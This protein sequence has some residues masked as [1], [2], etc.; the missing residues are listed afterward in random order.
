MDEMTIS[1]TDD[2]PC[3][4]WCGAP[5][6]RRRGGRQQAFCTPAHSVLVGA[7]SVRHESHLRG[8]FDR[9]RGF[10]HRVSR[11]AEGTLMLSQCQSRLRTRRT[12]GSARASSAPNRSGASFDFYQAAGLIGFCTKSWAG[13]LAN[14]SA[15]ARWFPKKD[16]AGSP[17]CQP[18]SVGPKEK[19]FVSRGPRA[20]NTARSD[21][22]QGS[23]D[24]ISS[25]PSPAF[26]Q[27][28]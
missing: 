7:I 28:G 11:P 20:T 17:K 5:F 26:R 4:R 9:R 15:R 19:C 13:V 23:G 1:R 25:L 12:T 24:L 2:A 3:C 16:A 6:V 21:P 22:P 14:L 27:N 8:P 18:A 10:G